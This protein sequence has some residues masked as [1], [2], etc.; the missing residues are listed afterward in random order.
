MKAIFGALSRFLK[1]RREWLP[2]GV[3]RVGRRVFKLVG[4]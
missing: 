1:Q 3:E 4:R 2:A